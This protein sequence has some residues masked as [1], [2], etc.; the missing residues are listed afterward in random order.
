MS[1]ENLLEKLDEEEVEQL[2]DE[3]EAELET[4]DRDR[5]NASLG[6]FS[7]EVE[8]HESLDDT[9]ETF[10]E[11]WTGRVEE[12]EESRANTLKKSLEGDEISLF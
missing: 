8:S 4:R 2:A 6:M 10:V 3:V 11:L 1:D 12:V 7:L 9:A 5:I